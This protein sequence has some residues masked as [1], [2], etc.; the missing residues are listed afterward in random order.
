MN[1]SEEAVDKILAALRNAESPPGME[2]RILREL[3]HQEAIRSQRGNWPTWLSLPGA[4]SLAFGTAFAG[5]FVVVLMIPTLV[6][7]RH[8]RPASRQTATAT[9]LPA[10]ARSNS[11]AQPPSAPRLQS[12]QKPKGHKTAIVHPEDAQALEAMR[13]PSQPAPPL[14]LTEQEKL[15][16]R[17]AHK[18]DPQQLAMLNTQLRLQ[19]EKE[20]K[21]DFQNF[22]EP[23]ASG[24]K[25]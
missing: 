22:F 1:H 19:E 5:L 10:P 17:I 9:P 13:A 11:P 14:P 23:P 25:Q 12:S 20:E 15:L 2:L 4:R 6:R 21:A 24:E 18:G 8:P 16:L 7:L 3:Q